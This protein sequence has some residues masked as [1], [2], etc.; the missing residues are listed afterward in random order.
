MPVENTNEESLRLIQAQ[1]YGNMQLIRSMHPQIAHVLLGP[2]QEVQQ[3][4]DHLSHLLQ[5]ALQTQPLH[6]TP[7]DPLLQHFTNSEDT[8]NNGLTEPGHQFLV[9]RAIVG[10]LAAASHN[11]RAAPA[12]IKDQLPALLQQAYDIFHF[13]YKTL[14]ALFPTEQHEHLLRTIAENSLWPEYVTGQYRRL[15]PLIAGLAFWRHPDKAVHA[16]LLATDPLAL[17]ASPQ[18]IQS[19][20]QDACQLV[21]VLPLPIRHQFYVPLQRALHLLLSLFTLPHISIPPA[22]PRCLFRRQIS[23]DTPLHLLLK[24]LT[25]LLRHIIQPGYQWQL[26]STICAVLTITKEK[27]KHV[28]QQSIHLTWRHGIFP[29]KPQLKAISPFE[30]H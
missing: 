10:H 14:E 8:H 2:C 26:A 4:I 25:T 30:L 19:H 24:K 17:K 28:C 9:F 22:T 3:L 5:L 15:R 7:H 13:N 18:P 11:C 1:L 6:A 12:L 21:S 16:A 27:C 29:L 23:Q 20:L